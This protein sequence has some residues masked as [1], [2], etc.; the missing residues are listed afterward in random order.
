[1]HSEIFALWN[2][3]FK[4]F[5]AEI[6]SFIAAI[7]IPNECVQMASVHILYYRQIVQ[8]HSSIFRM[9]GRIAMAVAEKRQT[10]RES[11][12]WEILLLRKIL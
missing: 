10:V 1:M 6:P 5:T 11:G 3:T 8:F 4:Y 9:F 12:E 2:L 7:G